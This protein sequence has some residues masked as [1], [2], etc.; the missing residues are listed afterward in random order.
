MSL[1]SN[2]LPI[3]PDVP[4]ARCG[5]LKESYLG[6]PGIRGGSAGVGG[7][8]TDGGPTMSTGSGF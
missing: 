2:S 4:S 3:S 6:P 7:L 8:V 1:G 5:G